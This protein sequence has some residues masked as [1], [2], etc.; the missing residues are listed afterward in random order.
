MASRYVAL[1]LLLAGILLAGSLPL[2]ALFFAVGA[3]LGLTDALIYRRAGGTVWPHAAAAGAGALAAL[4]TLA[5]LLLTEAGAVG[6]A[7]GAATGALG[8]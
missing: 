3:Y 6:A 2:L 1:G 7:A 5:A 8:D 4:V